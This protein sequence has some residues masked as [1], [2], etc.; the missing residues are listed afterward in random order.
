M[1]YIMMA[2]PAELVPAVTEF[3]ERRQEDTL[4][5]LTSPT[6][7]GFVHGWNR[8]TVRRAYRESGDEMRRL[9]GFLA[10]NPD[11][12]I[13]SYELA[14]ALEARFGWNSIAGM[15][16]AFRRRCGNRYGRTEPMWEVR[17][18]KEGHTLLRMPG[19]TAEVIR[20][21]KRT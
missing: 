11:R 16:G 1:S 4:P 5:R 12:E 15:L 10:Q 19:S 21:A 6:E 3:I 18:D 14:D 8:E 20:E 17:Y 2:I 7:K 9:L 13:S